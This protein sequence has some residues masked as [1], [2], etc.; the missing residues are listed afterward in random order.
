MEHGRKLTATHEAALSL[1]L[2]VFP[3][4]PS[5]NYGL[6]SVPASFDVILSHTIHLPT[7]HHEMVLK[8]VLAL[9]VASCTP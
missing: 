8:A 4:D 6:A 9:G 7:H 2:V 3:F 1:K 5:F